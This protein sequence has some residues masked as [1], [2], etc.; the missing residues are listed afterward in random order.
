[1]FSSG[2]KG[3]YFLL[4]ISL[5]LSISS[6][7]IITRATISS[8]NQAQI[9][10]WT[11]VKSCT[12]QAFT[13]GTNYYA[14]NCATGV[15]DDGGP[16]NAGGVT[17]TSASAVIQAAIT[18]TSSG[19]VVEILHGL[20]IMTTSLSFGAN[21]IALVGEN[22]NS[23]KL[24]WSSSTA[25]LAIDFNG[26]EGITVANLWIKGNTAISTQNGIELEDGTFFGRIYNIYMQNFE[27]SS[28]LLRSTL[29]VGV[30]Y[31]RFDHLSLIGAGTTN[32]GIGV[33]INLF[34][35]SSGFVNGN[36]FSAVN[37]VGWVWGVV[38][39][40][41]GQVSNDQFWGVAISQGTYGLRILD[42]SASSDTL[43]M[44]YDGGTLTLSELITSVG[45][46]ITITE[47]PQAYA[48]GIT[49]NTGKVNRIGFIPITKITNP[50][51]STSNTIGLSGNTAT[52]VAL[53]N[54]VVT[55]IPIILS[56]SGGSGVTITVADNAG[57]NIAT[58]GACS[59]STYIT[60]NVGNVI[61]FGAFSA[62]PTI[63]VFGF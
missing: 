44:H 54:Y 56:C 13:D 53:T 40:D 15:I 47:D 37:L 25:A 60:A 1:M 32:A 33:G 42:A 50:L 16:L 45:T 6:M 62:S 38:M 34:A 9:N 24:D 12:Y 18:A 36:Y 8:T 46:G 4:A 23:T 30:S 11:T 57:N 31:N 2:K 55:G 48:D 19:G 3:T 21:N 63:S 59:A 52:P 10:Q 58:P 43:Q 41:T 51:S 27:G 49:D 35:T 29:D 17:G 61:N 28:I 20:Y 26:K 39:Q 22:E 14:Q 5:I 7:W